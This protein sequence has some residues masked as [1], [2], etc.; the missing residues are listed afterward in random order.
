[1]SSG[2]RSGAPCSQG[3]DYR[4]WVGRGKEE[5]QSEGGD[6]GGQKLLKTPKYEIMKVWTRKGA[7]VQGGRNKSE[8]C[9]SSGFRKTW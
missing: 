9:R 6:T 4:C 2:D 8:C 5:G 7:E 3:H 1:M